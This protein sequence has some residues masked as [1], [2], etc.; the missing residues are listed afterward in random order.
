[1]HKKELKFE[2]NLVLELKETNKMRYIKHFR[3]L[4]RTLR[5]EFSSMKTPNYQTAGLSA[6][7]P[8]TTDFCT[9]LDYDNIKDERLQDELVYLQEYFRLGDFHIFATNKYGRNPICI[10]RMPLREELE[11]VNASTCDSNFK[12]GI[13]LNE[14]RT[15]ILR[16]EGKGNRPAPKY[17]YSLESPYNGQRQQSLAHTIFLKLHYNAKVRLANSDGNFELEIQPYKTSTKTDVKDVE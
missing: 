16:S 6:R 12:R 2:Q 9:F 11:V 13:R 5:Y 4:D 10:D 17:L 7:I 8:H 3:F 15:W 14:Y 1:M